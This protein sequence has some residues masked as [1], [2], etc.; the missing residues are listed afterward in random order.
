MTKWS[1][2]KSPL[3]KV[4]NTIEKE[5][6]V[7]ETAAGFYRPTNIVNNMVSASITTTDGRKIDVLLDS[8]TRSVYPKR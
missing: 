1:D 7:V 3:D 5:A 6:D 8:E 2:I 4:S